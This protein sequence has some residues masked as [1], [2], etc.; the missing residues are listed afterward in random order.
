MKHNLIFGH[1]SP[2]T[3]S[4]C[5]AISLS[6]LKN[7]LHEKSRPYVL[8]KLNKET[9][10]VLNY[11]NTEE[12]ELLKNVKI[13]IKDLNYEKVNPIDYKKSINHAYFYMNENRL[14]TLPIVDEENHLAGLITMKDIAMSLINTDQ[15]LLRTS[16][17]NI[18]E[19][20][21]GRVL[22]KFD[23]VIDGEI[24][25]A[26][27]E[28]KTLRK[29]NILHEDSLVIVGDRNDVIG[30]AVEIGVKL[31]IVTGNLDISEELINEAEKNKVNIIITPHQTYYTA[32]NIGLSKH[33]QSIMKSKDLV[34]FSELDYLD[35]CKEDIQSSKHSKFPI[36][37]RDKKYLGILSR[38]DI[39]NPT[40]K[41]V[42]LV[43]HNEY[44]QSAEGIEQA[45][46]LEVIDHHKIGDIKTVMPI[47]FRNI[48]VGSSNTIIYRMYKENGVSVDKN[49]AGLMLS[50]IVSDTLL[51]KSPTT[52]GY[53]RE[54]VRELSEIAEVNVNEYAMEMFKAGTSLESKTM[55]EVLFEDFKKFNLEYNDVAISQVFTLD[56][57]QIME[58]KEEYIKLIDKVTEDKNYYLVIMAV[59]DIIKEGS[60]IFYSSSREKLIE[61]IFDKDSVYEGV[62]IEDCVSRKKQIVPSVVNALNNLK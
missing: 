17:E 6:N 58:N 27:F 47:T 10:F 56:I 25:V 31:I 55:E 35:D 57:N 49:I 1:R 8:G 26:S 34:L 39:I 59:T 50:G 60:Y 21:Q 54:A 30:Y 40:K 15:R 4:V 29:A 61:S 42:I 3:D 36:I 33:V 24:I 43:D 37:S 20:L 45:D 48:P 51:L 14:N 9:Q 62:Y 22:L 19:T 46:I 28:E 23:D 32:K 18:V 38:K 52:T 2:D 12:P 16:F 53:D 7:K 41:K 13:Q 11:F 44:A 5:A